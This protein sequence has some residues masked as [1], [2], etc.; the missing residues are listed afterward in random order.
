[1]PM[2]TPQVAISRLNGVSATEK[3]SE[4]LERKSISAFRSRAVRRQRHAQPAREDDVVQRRDA[5]A[6]AIVSGHGWRSR[7]RIRTTRNSTVADRHAEHV[8]QRDERDASRRGRA[9]AAQALAARQPRGPGSC[10]RVAPTSS[11]AAS[12]AITTPSQNG[13]N[14]GPGPFSPQYA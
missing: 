4:R 7:K 5:S 12:T 11:I 8:Q 1:M 3:P 6:T 10:E 2:T 9:R 13:R 14:A